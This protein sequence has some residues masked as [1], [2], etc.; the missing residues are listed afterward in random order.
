MIG[1]T[2]MGYAINLEKFYSSESKVVSDA[3]E[4]SMNFKKFPAA[5]LK[6]FSKNGN[7]TYLVFRNG[8]ISISGCKGEAHFL[9]SCEYIETLLKK[10]RA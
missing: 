7:V 5:V 10:Y 8:S 4:V 6:T 2:S 1:G 3:Q 9:K